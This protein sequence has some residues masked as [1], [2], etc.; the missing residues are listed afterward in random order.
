MPTLKEQW[1]HTENYCRQ[2]IQCLAH[3][4]HSTNGAL[5]IFSTIIKTTNSQTISYWVGREFNNPEKVNYPRE[6]STSF[7]S[8]TELH[9]LCAHLA[10]K[11]VTCPEL[12]PFT[13]HKPQGLGLADS[14]GSSA[15]K[16]ASIC[17]SFFPLQANLTFKPSLIRTLQR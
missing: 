13:K 16:G 11:N 8:Q 1:D 12:L 5:I 6:F 4:N 9:K 15:D 2:S 3:G 17:L 14:W 7:S 10:L